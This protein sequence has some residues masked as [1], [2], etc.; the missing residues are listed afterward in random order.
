MQVYFLVQC[1]MQFCNEVMVNGF[2]LCCVLAFCATVLNTCW[3]FVIL[4]DFFLSHC[5]VVMFLVFLDIAMLVFVVDK[6]R[7]RRE[8]RLLMLSLLRFRSCM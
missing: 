6:K 1:D 8:R 3:E 5:V 2:F 4:A 7:E